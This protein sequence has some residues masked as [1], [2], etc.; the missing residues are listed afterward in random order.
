[1]GRW[2][3]GAKRATRMSIVTTL[4]EQKKEKYVP[5]SAAARLLTLGKNQSISSFERFPLFF[6][7]I[8]SLFSLVRK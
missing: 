4:S 2:K 6:H 5:E 1:M 8:G 7:N 3:K